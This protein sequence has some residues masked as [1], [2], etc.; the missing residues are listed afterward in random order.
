MRPPI[1]YKSGEL[2]VISVASHGHAKGTW[3]KCVCSCGNATEIN[4]WHLMNR[5][6]QSCRPCA[7]KKS[8]IKAQ[9]AWQ[10][11]GI[12]GNARKSGWTPEYR[13]YQCM[14]TRC[15][16]RN[17]ED[18]KWYGARGITVCERWRNSFVAFMADVG[19]KPAGGYSLDRINNDGN[20]EP[21]NV[22]W[23]THKQQATNRRKRQRKTA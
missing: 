19:K 12:H 14:L 10:K 7:N 3:A 18:W 22:R 1:G 2:T 9:E 17:R 16:N 11:N 15:T 8:I 20:Y 13:A 23:A 21:G 6:P 5:K 4:V